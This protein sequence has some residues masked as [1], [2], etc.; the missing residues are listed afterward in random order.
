MRTLGSRMLEAFLLRRTDEQFLKSA[1]EVD[2]RLAHLDSR[3]EG[4]VR[5]PINGIY[6]YDGAW[7]HAIE[8]LDLADT[9]GFAR[10]LEAAV[11]FWVTLRLA[12]GHNRFNFH[13]AE[14]NAPSS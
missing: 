12:V 11:L 4:D 6:C 14:G 10:G 3:L 7:Q 5:Y 2:L 1:E 8:R 13:V 9:A